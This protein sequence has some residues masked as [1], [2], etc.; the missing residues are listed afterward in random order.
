VLGHYRGKLMGILAA[1]VA[2]L[3][4]LTAQ[5]LNTRLEMASDR[6]DSITWYYE[7]E[8]EIAKAVTKAV[9]N[10]TEEEIRA[11]IAKEES[12]GE[13]QV[14]PEDVDAEEVQEWQKE[15]PKYR[16]LAAGKITAEQLYV[17]DVEANEHEFV[18]KLDRIFFIL[19]VV[20]VFNIV[21]IFI[22]V[23]AAFLTAKGDE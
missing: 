22:G 7:E 20:G 6:E 15:L 10:G 1:T 16:D 4:I 18:T 12:Y 21:N 8:M 3:A 11:Y 13:F 17:Q 23:G 9:P 2:L 14:K 5:F 19:E